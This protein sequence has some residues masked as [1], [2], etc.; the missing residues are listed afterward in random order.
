MLAGRRPP[1]GRPDWSRLSTG[2]IWWLVLG[3]IAVIV[4]VVALLPSLVNAWSLTHP[5]ATA[6]VAAGSDV[7]C[8]RC[9]KRASVLLLV[10]GRKVLTTLRAPFQ[11]DGYYRA[12][13]PVVYERDHPTEAMAVPDRE[14][15]RGPVPASGLA[16]ALGALLPA[17]RRA[18]RLAR[19]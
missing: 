19:P 15:G 16:L 17:V 8:R 9:S 7:P 2:L 12:G 4:A 1:A 11:E 6:A 14:F 13:I 3:W 18:S 5:V 10:Q